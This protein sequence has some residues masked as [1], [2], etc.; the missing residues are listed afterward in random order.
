MKI[1]SCYSIR[2]FDSRERLHAYIELFDLQIVHHYQGVV[3]EVYIAEDANHNKIDL[4]I[5]QKID[6]DNPEGLRINVDNIEEAIDRYTQNGYRLV[7]GVE[8]D[9]S[10]KVATLQ[11]ESGSNLLI[12]QH[13]SPKMSKYIAYCGLNCETCEARIATINN[14]DALREKVALEWGQMNG[15]EFQKE[16]INCEGCRIDGVKTGF[17]DSMCEIRQCALGKAYESCRDCIEMKECK[18]LKMITDNSEEAKVNLK[19]I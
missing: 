18:K 6:C 9:E 3:S 7:F 14:D 16:W 17:C 15:M 10:R 13:K 8:E 12:L 5:P 1:S 11:D 4:A 19:T 2:F